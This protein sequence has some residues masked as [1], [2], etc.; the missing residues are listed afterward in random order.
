MDRRTFLRSSG[1]VAGA[2]AV[3]VAASQSLATP[4]ITRSRHRFSVATRFPIAQPGTSTFL[5]RL[6]ESVLAMSDGRLELAPATRMDEASVADVTLDFP[7]ADGEMSFAHDVIA[8]YPGGLSP[9]MFVTWLDFGGGARLW[10][11]IADASGRKT[12]YAGHTGGDPMLWSKHE[13]PESESLAGRTVFTTGFGCRLVEALGGTLASAPK[14]DLADG[15]SPFVDFIN[16]LPNGYGWMIESPFHPMGRTLALSMPRTLWDSIAP[17]DQALLEAAVA[18]NARLVSTETIAH[19]RIT[20]STLIMRSRIR[21]MQLERRLHRRAET[22][23][24]DLLSSGAATN[25]A[26]AKLVASMRG[27]AQAFSAFSSFDLTS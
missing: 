18:A 26:T 25:L 11:D 1:A 19:R 20:L 10:G 24:Q 21:P 2:S 8:G 9:A 22:I 27:C 15:F 6:S 14:A 17:A 7:Q 3:P 16:G 13:E 12:F 4:A 5:I 23:A